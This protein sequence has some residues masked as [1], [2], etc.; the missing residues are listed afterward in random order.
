LNTG[1]AIDNERKACDTVERAIEVQY[2]IEHTIIKAFAG[3]IHTGVDFRSFIEP[4]APALALPI[5]IAILLSPAIS[6]R[7]VDHAAGAAVSLAT[8][9]KSIQFTPQI[10]PSRSSKLRPYMKS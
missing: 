4:I 6:A 8:A 5:I 7:S 9:S 10:W 2:A 3:Q 1:R